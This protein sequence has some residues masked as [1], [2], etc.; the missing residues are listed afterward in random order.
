MK[1]NEFEKLL[2]DSIQ[3]YGHEYPELPTNDISEIH[4]FPDNF[5]D[6]ILPHTKPKK[7]FILRHI[8]A[9]SAAAAV[10]V[11]GLAAVMIFSKSGAN[12][13]SNMIDKS[14]RQNSSVSMIENENAVQDSKNSS[15]VP[16][17]SKPAKDETQTTHLNEQKKDPVKSDD[18]DNAGST[19][20]EV[21]EKTQTEEPTKTSHEPTYEVSDE[22]VYENSEI[23]Q[24]DMP[25]SSSDE[26]PVEVSEEIP[27]EESGEIPVEVSDEPTEVSDE[28]PDITVIDNIKT[29][30]YQNNA[31][32]PVNNSIRNIL[33]AAK[34][35]MTDS[36]SVDIY[37]IYPSDTKT[38]YVFK[39]IDSSINIGEKTYSTI[40]LYDTD[41][42]YIIVAVK[43]ADLEAYL[44]TGSES[45]LST[46]TS[47]LEYLSQ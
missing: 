31:D 35:Y 28:M 40:S 1:D 37:S 18:T 13:T 47:A 16:S 4:R 17:S 22:P 23:N 14:V 30:V 26:T 34:E 19:D 5:I 7:P 25:V 29:F 42:G 27:S 6:D 15:S 38:T 9:F 2:Q 12:N 11:I 20:S 24:E 3:L 10:M 32:D 8:R 33:A 45:D 44:M 43:D 21:S 46:V 39:P 41:S 36:Y